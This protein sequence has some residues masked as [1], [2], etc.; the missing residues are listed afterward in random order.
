MFAK[1]D[2]FPCLIPEDVVV[3]GTETRIQ[4]WAFLKKF[5]EGQIHSLLSCRG[6]GGGG[7][8]ADGQ[9]DSTRPFP[10]WFLSFPVFRRPKRTRMR[11]G[12]GRSH[13]TCPMLPPSSIHGCRGDGQ[14]LVR[15][16]CVQP[17][18]P[19]KTSS[20]NTEVTVG[21]G[22]GCSRP[23]R[24]AGQ[25]SCPTDP[26]A[27]VLQASCVVARPAGSQTQVEAQRAAAG[28]KLY[29]AGQHPPFTKRQESYII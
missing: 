6:R 4:A 20:R 19:L 27:A 15:P 10:S 28:R 13:M 21:P 16:C 1:K 29:K 25:F 2:L 9:T 5:S 18:P 7:G 23:V 24:R 22:P 26:R 8:A 17:L 12:Q 3:R 14:P 11:A